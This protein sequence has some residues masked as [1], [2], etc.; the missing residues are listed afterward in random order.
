MT[1]NQHALE[2]LSL[3]LPPDRL[4]QVLSALKQ[5]E[6]PQDKAHVLEWRALA[7]EQTALLFK[8][9]TISLTDETDQVVFSRDA[10]YELLDLLYRHRND[11]HRAVQHPQDDP[12]VLAGEVAAARREYQRIAAESV[13]AA[14]STDETA[15]EEILTWI[16][17]RREEEGGDE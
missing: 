7:K 2:L 11:I 15:R 14:N 3:Y 6:E 4:A 1:M 5:K 13:R 8:D 10:T 17:S 9:G 12:D 16:E